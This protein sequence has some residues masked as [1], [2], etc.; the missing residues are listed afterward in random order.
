[1]S[2]SANIKEQL[3]KRGTSLRAWAITQGYPRTTVYSVVYRW[4]HRVDRVPHGGFG[5]KIMADLRRDLEG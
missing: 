2:A 3:R 4:A 5:R 1:M